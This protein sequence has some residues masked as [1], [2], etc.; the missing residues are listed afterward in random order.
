MGYVMQALY[1]LII[2]F[3][4]PLALILTKNRKAWLW[5]VDQG[6]K[7]TLLCAASLLLTR[8]LAFNIG[9]KFFPFEEWVGTDVLKGFLLTFGVLENYPI[10]SLCGWRFQLIPCIPS[11][12]LGLEYFLFDLLILFALFSFLR[13]VKLHLAKKAFELE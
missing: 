4:Y 7:G 9:P 11:V 12:G 6:W 3:P 8:I 13:M 2:L 10:I 1:V 5:W